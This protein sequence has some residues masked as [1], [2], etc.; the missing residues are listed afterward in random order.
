M[1]R[2]HFFF[3]LSLLLLSGAC[4]DQ[5]DPSPEP[6]LAEQ[7][8]EVNLVFETPEEYSPARLDSTTIEQFFQRN[9]EHLDNAQ[10][11]RDF[12]G[13]RDMQYAWI[14]NDTLSGSAGSFIAMMSSGDTLHPAVAAVRSDI[15]ELMDAR[16]DDR[17]AAELELALTA[18]FFRYASKRYEGLLPM[19]LKDLSWYIP[20]RKKNFDRL[21]DS[22]VHG[23]MDLSL[24]E[25]V[26]PQYFLLKQH[27]RDLHA[28]QQLPWNELELKDKKKLEPGGSADIIPAIRERLEQLGDLVAADT[29][30]DPLAYDSTLVTAVQHFQ[31]RHGLLADG[32]IGPRVLAWLNMS[33]QQRLRTVLVNMERLRWM[34]ERL[35]PDVLLV[36]IPEFKLHV[37]EGERIRMSMEVVVGTAATRTVIFS[38]TLSYLVFSPT[39]TIPQS[40]TRNEILPAMERDPQYL[41][42]KNMEIIGGSESHPVIRQRPG[43]GN[44]LGRVKF[45]FPNS[46]SI[47][48]HDTP[49]KSLFQREQR[50]FS[51][52]CIRVSRPVELAE[53][54]LRNDTAWTPEKIAEAMDQKEEVRVDLKEKRPVM[55]TYHTA[56]VDEQ[57]ALQFR[58]DIYDHDARLA[59]ELFSTSEQHQIAQEQRHAGPEDRN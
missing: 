18:Q 11:V 45:M 49:A 23:A 40:I 51:H 15:T 41:R 33:P 12:Y 6:T 43:A 35:D 21:L 28:L 4:N 16:L 34:P 48:L 50:A 5:R 42:K 36:N 19:D 29:L 1:P 17:N 25:P 44:S 20:K 58:E 10:A 37:Y 24:V 2:L 31:Q 30:A 8:E 13:R 55:I 14:V 53:Y 27:L 32:I 46:F 54:L 52:G 7:I 59:R 56:W 22:L 3:L 9:P 38:D 39:W 26:H 57:G 47:Y